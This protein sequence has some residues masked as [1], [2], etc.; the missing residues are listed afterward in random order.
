M[1]HWLNCIGL[2]RHNGG[3]AAD[4]PPRDKRD[5]LARSTWARGARLA[6]L[7]LG[8]AGRATV[9]LGKRIG[10]TP[11]ETVS[12]QMQD[13]AARQLF[14]VLGELKGGAMKFGQA[15]SLFEAVLPEEVAA[16]YR[17]QLRRL[18]DSAPPMPTSRVN[19][20]LERELGAGWRELFLDFDPLP[21]AAAS[22]GQ[23]H[24]AVWAADGQPVAVKVQYPGADAALRSDLRQIG[25]L[26]GVVSPLTGGIDVKPLVSELT[27]RISEEVDYTIEAENQAQAAA[28]FAGHDEFVVPEVLTHTSRVLVSQWVEGEPFSSVTARDEQE[29]SALALR[30]VRFLFAGPSTAGLLHAD[31]HPGNFRVLEDG[32]LGV[33]DWGLVARLPEGLPSAMGRILRIAA[34]GNAEQVL[35]GLRVEGFLAKNVNPDDLL[36]YLSPFVEPAAVAEFHFNR[37]WMREQYRRVS[38]SSASGGIS[39]R[40]NLPPNYLLI[41]RVWLGGVAV[42]SQLDVRARFREVLE[43]FL[44]GYARSG[45][46]Q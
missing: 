44:P 39:M 12:S 6:S 20:V 38:D 30:Y 35:E 17:A 24:R 18:Q 43:E 14:S 2:S 26:A 42:L 16:P 29:R 11:A 9:G 36:D 31:P 5:T 33:V 13:R 15:L 25:R 4:K 19:A 23:V 45:L 21:A 7:P 28:A 22:I 32:R 34:D 46:E 40:L 3:M 27:A 1:E 10:G 8:F 37:D 41:H